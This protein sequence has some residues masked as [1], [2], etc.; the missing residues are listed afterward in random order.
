MKN[1]HFIKLPTPSFSWIILF[2]YLFQFTFN[3]TAQEVTIK[4]FNSI[5]MGTT[6]TL[7]IYVPDSYEKDSTR[8]FPITILLDGDFLFDVYLG[9]MKLFAQRDL[10]PDQILVGVFQNQGNERSTDTAFDKVSGLPTEE[11]NKFYRFVGGELLDYME[12]N[13]RVSPFRTIVG[14]TTTA[15]FI[16]YYLS[17]NEPVFDAYVNINPYFNEDMF[18]FLNTKLS[19]LERSKVYMYLNSGKYNKLEIHK[20]IEQVAYGLKNLENPNILVKYDIFDNST[21][22]SSIGQAIP[23]ALAHIFSGY[24]YISPEEFD[25]NIKHLTPPDAIDYLRTKY[26]D[27][28]YLFGTN[29][30][31]RERDILAIESIVID[32]ENGKYLAE[33]GSMIEKLYSKSPLS[34]YYIGMFYEKQGKYKQALKYY[35]NGY[36]KMDQNIEKA[37]KYYQNIER[38]QGRADEVIQA[39]EQ[40]KNNRD[41]KKEEWKEQKKAEEEMK[42]KYRKK[43]KEN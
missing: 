41:A 9:N 3:I 6:R 26:V 27:I 36:A 17:E 20:K 2:F 11:S 7:K 16:N 30:K 37:E 28:D 13:Y 12:K 35:K 1:N 8:Y 33:F 34:D 25:M 10:A 24:A 18:T 40:E 15:N 5:E 4:R 38:V 14:S 43:G 32:Q 19:G 42:D 29:L 21:K 39:E 23:G 22:T 31:I